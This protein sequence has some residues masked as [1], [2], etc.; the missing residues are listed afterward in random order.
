MCNNII[1]AGLFLALFCLHTTSADISLPDQAILLPRR[2]AEMYWAN[3]AL[4]NKFRKYR[5]YSAVQSMTPEDKRRYS[6]QIQL[7]LA[8]LTSH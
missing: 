8:E 7:R 6:Q 4:P 5:A 3:R 2:S 1:V